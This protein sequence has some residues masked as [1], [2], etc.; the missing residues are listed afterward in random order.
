MS[1]N[2]TET[3]HEKITKTVFPSST[4]RH[5]EFLNRTHRLGNKIRQQSALNLKKLLQAKKK[6]ELSVENLKRLFNKN[7]PSYIGGEHIRSI[8][9]DFNKSKRLLEPLTFRCDTSRISMRN[10]EMNVNAKLLCKI[11][12]TIK[13]IHLKDRHS[14]FSTYNESNI[15]TKRSKTLDIRKALEIGKF[16]KVDSE[17]QVRLKCNTF[18]LYE[19]S[20]VNC[21]D[22]TIV[23][24]YL[25]SDNK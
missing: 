21:Q 7:P 9:N 25:K 18:I 1:F 10:V 16:L 2:Y 15:D 22:S 11:R 6:E 20:L 4:L 19:I 3:K 8:S 23:L 17:T 14:K 24:G 5:V 13:D 12:S